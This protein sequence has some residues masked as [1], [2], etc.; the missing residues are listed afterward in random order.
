LLSTPDVIVA[1]RLQLA[2][3][4]FKRPPR[5]SGIGCSSVRPSVAPQ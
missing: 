3:R 4:S 1:H 5:Y 2:S